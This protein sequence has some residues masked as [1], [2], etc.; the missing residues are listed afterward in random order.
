MDEKPEEAF[1]H[2]LKCVTSHVVEK[3]RKKME[4]A[5]SSIRRGPSYQVRNQLVNL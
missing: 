1:D 2:V 4:E 3:E 5:L